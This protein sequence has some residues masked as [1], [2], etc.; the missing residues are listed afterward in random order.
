MEVGTSE[1][2]MVWRGLHRRE[3]PVLGGSRRPPPF[4]R[5][6]SVARVRGVCF[7]SPCGRTV[8][9]CHCAADLRVLSFCVF[10]FSPSGGSLPVETADRAAGPGGGVLFDCLTVLQCTI[11]RDPWCGRI[12][13][14]HCFPQRGLEKRGSGSSKAS[15]GT[16]CGGLAGPVERAPGETRCRGHA[17]YVARL[18]RPFGARVL[19][20]PAGLPLVGLGSASGAAYA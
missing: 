18:L 4:A 10:F 1:R 14:G 7:A 5:S 2:W 20:D 13:F 3:Q 9:L 19:R 15:L 8:P 17:H 16:P 6:G 11:E 12:A